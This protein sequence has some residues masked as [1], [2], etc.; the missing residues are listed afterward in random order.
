MTTDRRDSGKVKG[1]TR[2]IDLNDVQDWFLKDGW[3]ASGWVIE[4][5][6][7]S[8]KEGWNTHV[9]CRFAIAGDGQRHYVREGTV[10]KGSQA[11]HLTF[12]YDRL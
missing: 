7:W 10:L 6:V 3:E 5:E 8:E 12:V 4:T 11:E 9:V 2:W 1:R